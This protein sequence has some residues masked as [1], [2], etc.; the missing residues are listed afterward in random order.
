MAQAIDKTELSTLKLEC[1]HRDEISKL[2]EEHS[3]LR[4]EK[5]AEIAKLREEKLKIAHTAARMLCPKNKLA[6]LDSI[7]QT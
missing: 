6:T 5:D 1:K 7:F 2:R 3:H 4:D